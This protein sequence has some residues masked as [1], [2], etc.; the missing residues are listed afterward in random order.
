MSPGLTSGPVQHFS[1]ETPLEKSISPAQVLGRLEHDRNRMMGD[2][3]ETHHARRMVT[4]VQGFRGAV[5]LS[6]WAMAGC[7]QT[8]WREE[9]ARTGREDF[10]FPQGNILA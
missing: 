8:D 3:G 9:S 7:T 6:L 4:T 5:G 2:P 1:P 10:C